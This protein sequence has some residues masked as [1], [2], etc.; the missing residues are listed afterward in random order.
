MLTFVVGLWLVWS[1]SLYHLHLVCSGLVRKT[2]LDFK[3]LLE[4]A[5]LENP[6]QV[7]ISACQLWGESPKQWLSLNAFEPRYGE[8]FQYQEPDKLCFKVNSFK[9]IW[10]GCRSL[11]TKSFHLLICSYHVVY[12]TTFSS[13][14][15]Q[16]SAGFVWNTATLTICNDT[17]SFNS[18]SGDVHIYFSRVYI[19]IV[20]CVIHCHFR[21]NIGTTSTL[22]QSLAIFKIES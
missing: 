5:K 20:A 3:F 14:L 10:Q 22:F 7:L 17:L 12:V 21:M 1:K 11:S 16:C 13:M 4:E 9:Y 2:I 18:L 8:D 6:H 19:C 15:I